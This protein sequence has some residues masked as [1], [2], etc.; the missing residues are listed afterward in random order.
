MVLLSFLT[1]ILRYVQTGGLSENIFIHFI[2]LLLYVIKT[3][4]HNALE[5]HCT[6]K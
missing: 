6:I 2:A 4:Y 1:S 5:L 3:D